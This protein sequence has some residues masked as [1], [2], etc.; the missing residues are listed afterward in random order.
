MKRN[1]LYN[2][3]KQIPVTVEQS[4]CLQIL[5]DFLRNRIKTIDQV[6]GLK[7]DYGYGGG[8]APSKDSLFGSTFG[9]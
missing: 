8:S 6:K 7:F 9:G 3:L 1:Y 4:S 5:E 2:E